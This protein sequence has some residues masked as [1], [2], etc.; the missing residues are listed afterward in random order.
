MVSKNECQL[1][2]NINCHTDKFKALVCNF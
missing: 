2:L 1:K